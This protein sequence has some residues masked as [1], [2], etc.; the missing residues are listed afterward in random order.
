MIHI[1]M[2]LGYININVAEFDSHNV[3]G[4]LDTI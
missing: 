2:K 3:G 1:S 4:E